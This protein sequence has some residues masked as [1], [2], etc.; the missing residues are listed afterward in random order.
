VVDPRGENVTATQM[1]NWPVH[2]EVIETCFCKK[3]G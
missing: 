1:I 3:D 2:D